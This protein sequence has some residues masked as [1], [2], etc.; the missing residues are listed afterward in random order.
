[1]KHRLFRPELAEAP[2]PGTGAPITF[3]REQAH[4]LCRVLRLKPGAEIGVFDGAGR[5][6]RA[7]LQSAEPRHCEAILEGLARTSN[8][9]TP[10]VLALSWLKG[11]ALDSV[12][13]KAVEL[14]ATGIWLIDAERGNVKLDG[15]RRA[16]RIA[17]L[18]KIVSSAAEQCETLW[19]PELTERGTLAEVLND[20]AGLQVVLLDTQAPVL[21]VA[22]EP[23]PLLLLVGPEGGWSDAERH[24][25]LREGAVRAG[26]GGLTLRAET[27]PLAALAAIRHSWGWER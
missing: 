6:W 23:A 11:S 3:D 10:L 1:M 7:R 4:Y 21:T 14:G 26:L 18:T 5:E 22:E 13:Q 8:R 9:P 24:L 25:A 15:R 2:E 19:R 20:A 16:N 17:H 27:A 12:I